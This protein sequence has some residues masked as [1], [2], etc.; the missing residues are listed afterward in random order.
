MAIDLNV[1]SKNDFR[2]AIAEESSFGTAITAQGSFKEILITDIPQIEW[3]GIIR[4]EAKKSDGKRVFSHT[5]IYQTTAGGTYTCSVSGILTDITVDLLLYG[6]TQDLVSEGAN[7][8]YLKTFE[9]D[10]STDGDNSGVP[11]KFFTLNGYNPDTSEAWELKSCVLQNLT[12]STDPGTNGGRASFTATFFTGFPPTISG[13]TVTPAS[14]VTFG[15]DFYPFQTLNTKTIAA[16]DVVLGSFSI[17][18]ENGIVRVGYD[19]SGD[20]EQYFFPQFDVTGELSAKF[21]DNTAPEIDKWVLNP[22]DGSAE[23]NIIVQWG[24]GT[25]DGTLKFDI[26][27]IYSGHSYDFGNESGVFVSLPFR[28]VDDGTNEALEIKLANDTDR[29]W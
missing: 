19:S 8:P 22:V 26:N 27:A 12:I 25:A 18:I 15:S 9:I 2:F 21:D 23:S 10:G 13:L 16:N 20:P 7:S 14:W 1:Y 29:S 17:T 6:A 28:G 11:Y 5:D 24:D 4:D 3:G